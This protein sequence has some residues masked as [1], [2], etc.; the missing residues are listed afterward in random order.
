LLKP[1]SE[2]RA[3]AE[4]PAAEVSVDLGDFEA[5][6]EAI[7][8]LLLPADELTDPA[9]FEKLAR[10]ARFTEIEYA[11]LLQFRG[12]FASSQRKMASQVQPMTLES[13]VLQ[14]GFP[15][16]VIQAAMAGLYGK[17]IA[18]LPLKK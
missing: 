8:Q 15:A 18:L 3:L 9:R 14:F 7:G 2:K 16:E 12:Q 1:R 13:L 17:L 11:L 6:R 4:Q 10:K 5:V